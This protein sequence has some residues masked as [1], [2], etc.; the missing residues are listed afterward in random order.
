[1]GI[2]YCYTNKITGK[3]YIG[4]TIHPTQRK[5]NHLHSAMKLGS[6]YYFHRSI[7]KHGIENFEYEILEEC[8][9]LSERETFYIKEYNTIW[10]N[11]YNQLLE[12][13]VMP[14]EI[15]KKISES[16]KRKWINYSNEQKEEIIKTLRV[17]NLGKTQSETQKKAVATANSKRFLI[18]FPDGHT[19]EVFNL[20]QF[21][22]DHNVSAGNMWKPGMKSKGFKNIKE[23]ESDYNELHSSNIS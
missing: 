16:H 4:Q 7:R 23:L 18:E 17:A 19:E 13:Q 14:E 3:K 9:N 6:D 2:I 10:P 22:R 21:G 11:G 5:R 20:R 8:D 1:M 15:K 12:Q